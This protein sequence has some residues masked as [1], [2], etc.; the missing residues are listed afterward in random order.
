MKF[1]FYRDSRVIPDV[2]RIIT[3]GAFDGIH[4]GHQKLLHKVNA[5]QAKNPDA[6][7][8]LVTFEPLPH[9][10]FL[11]ENSPA[12]IMSLKEKLAYLKKSQ[13]VDEVIILPFTERLREES[14]DHFID[15]FLVDQLNIKG[16]VIGAD[17]RFGA[18]AAGSF[19][20]LSAAGKQ[21]GFEVVQED[22]YFIGGVRVSSTLVRE[23][24]AVSN[25]NQAELYLGRP[26]QIMSRVVYGNQLARKLGTATINLPLKRFKPPFTGVYNVKATLCRTKE[27][28]KGVA[29]IGYR[30]TVD[31]IK[32]NL[33]VHLHD[34]NRNL[35]GET[36]SVRFLS[37]IRDEKR[38]ESIE[39]LKAQILLDAGAS[40]DYFNLQK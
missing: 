11:K 35:Y 20:D 28:L 1:F 29:N 6:K 5:L 16:I 2:P 14:P 38:F 13:L 25:F 30:P 3:I 21:Y 32:P 34:I 15:H 12:R 4:L 23:A 17:F 36:F 24:L 9:E 19:E 10:F 26:Y 37:K 31:G 33:E 18:K 27:K 7:R 39:A 22:Y 8:T 40:R